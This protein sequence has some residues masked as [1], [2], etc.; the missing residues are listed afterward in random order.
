MNIV[1]FTLLLGKL[2]IMIN[3]ID[4]FFV[5]E[6]F[7]D[8]IR[9]CFRAPYFYGERDTAESPAIGLA[10]EI[11]KS[12]IS[13]MISNKIKSSI[14]EVSNLSLYRMYINCFAPGEMPYFHIDGESGITCIYY[15]N[16]EYDMDNGGETQFI[17]DNQS[18][19]I[20]PI[21]N[22]M[23]YFDANISHRATSFR[24]NHRFTIAIKYQ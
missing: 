8:I 7:Y 15:V 2:K 9:Y 14:P 22:R 17:F 24:R 19:N 20:L 11:E 23:C 4:N 5:K 13:D 3:Y 10:S 16:P 18:V 21:P 6:K 12:D 1:V